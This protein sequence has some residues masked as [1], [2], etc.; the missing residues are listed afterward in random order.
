[1]LHEVYITVFDHFKVKP[2]SDEDEDDDDD[3]DENNEML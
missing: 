2:F 3:D 1:M